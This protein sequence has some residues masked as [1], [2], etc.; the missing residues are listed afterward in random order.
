MRFLSA[1][2][3][4]RISFHD[5]PVEQI[6]EYAL[7]FFEQSLKQET[8]DFTLGATVITIK[9]LWGFKFKLSDAAVERRDHETIDKARKRAIKLLAEL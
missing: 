2:S 8:D 7:P 1:K 3:W 5:A 9:E 4:F 6:K